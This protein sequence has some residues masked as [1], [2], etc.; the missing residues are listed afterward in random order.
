VGAATACQQGRRH[1][2]GDIVRDKDKLGIFPVHTVR[3]TPYKAA[4]ARH[5][6][7]VLHVAATL[8]LDQRAVF[9]KENTAYE[10]AAADTLLWTMKAHNGWRGATRL[11]W[12][13]F[14]AVRARRHQVWP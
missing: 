11:Q 6:S 5:E 7:G 12:F 13:L 10:A 9:A 1:G 8:G 2:A 14:I 4:K 3:M